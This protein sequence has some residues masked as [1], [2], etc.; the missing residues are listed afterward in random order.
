[1]FSFWGREAFGLNDESR[2]V[3]AYDLSNEAGVNLDIDVHDPVAHS[4]DFLPGDF[5]VSW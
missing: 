1:M 4:D 3:F 5:L 2:Y